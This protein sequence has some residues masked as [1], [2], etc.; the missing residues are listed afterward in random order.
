MRDGN[1]REHGAD[2]RFVRQGLDA[3]DL[4]AE[5]VSCVDWA[6]AQA[7]TLLWK[8]AKVEVRGLTLPD[9]QDIMEGMSPETEEQ[10]REILACNPQN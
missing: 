2:G 6:K 7:V 8:T 3:D 10:I 4:T 1:G 5:P 9:T